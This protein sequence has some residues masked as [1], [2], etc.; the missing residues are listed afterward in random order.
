MGKTRNPYKNLVGKSEV[1]PRRRG[2]IILKLILRSE[3]IWLDSCGPRKSAVGVSYGRGIAA[4]GPIRGG[5]TG[6]LLASQERLC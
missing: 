1:K 4:R 6:R 3:K 2:R 5:L